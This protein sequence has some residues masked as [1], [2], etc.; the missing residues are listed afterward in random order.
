MTIASPLVPQS[1]A[2]FLLMV[3]RIGT[4]L[5]FMPGFAGR[6]VPPAIKVLAAL[7]LSLV[8]VPFTRPGAETLT[9]PASF[10]VGLAREFL[11]GLL[12]GF[13]I[14]VVFGAIEMAAS[15]VGAQIGLNLSGVFNPS[16]DLQGTPLN[17]FYLVAAALVFFSANGHHLVLMALHRSFQTVPIGSAALAD[18]AGT[19]IIALASLMFVDA[20][21]IGLPVAGT[22]L[23][24]DACLGVLNR[25]VPQMNVFF[26]GLPVKI[27]AGFAVLLL[28]LPFLIRVLAPMVTDGVI[29]AIG[30]AGAVAR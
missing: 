4:M 22:L 25:M 27:F 12:M 24:V 10:T 15:L 30:R 14:A 5:M 13:G 29:E 11:L 23:A 3:T 21:R 2:V 16:L 19:A 18:N 9:D 7:A 1:I 28:T 6:S 8:L 20:L 26:V 17:T